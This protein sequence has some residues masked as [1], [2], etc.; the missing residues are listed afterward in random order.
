MSTQM[1]DR[2]IGLDGVVAA[3]TSLSHVDGEKGELIIAGLPVERLAPITD[4]AGVAARLWSLA[5]GDNIDETQLQDDLGQVRAETFA[6]IP[7]LLNLTKGTPP[8]DAMRTGLASLR[9]SDRFAP[10]VVAFGAAPVIAAAVTRASEGLPAIAPDPKRSSAEDFLHMLRGTDPSVRDVK[11]LDAYLVT[12][13]DHGMN[14]STFTARVVAST[15]ADMFAAV[16]AG[17]CA[18]TGPLHGGA[19]GPVLDMLDAIETRERIAPWVEAALESGNRLMGFGHRI[20]RTRDPRADVLRDVLQ[21]LGTGNERLAFAREVERTALDL[22]K[23]RKSSRALDTNVE[24]YTALLLEALEI[25]RTAFTPIFAIGR[26]AGWTAHVQE[27]WRRGR[28]IRPDS[29]YIGP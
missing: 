18:L 8:I 4:H 11:A 23:Q 17:Y 25:P 1:K 5:T 9:P 19:P 21:T 14:A 7:A 28:L 13:S 3:E 20:Y 15:R 12:V 16:A 26:M 27:Q 29:R 24:F 2:P 6:A 10:H 22:L